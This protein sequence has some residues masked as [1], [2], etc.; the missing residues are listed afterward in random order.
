MTAVPRFLAT[1]VGSM[2]HI[3]P[4][5][6]LDVVLAAAPQA[7]IWPQLPK[8][9]FCEQMEVQ[10]TEGLP[11]ARVDHDARKLHFDTTGDTSEELAGFYE[12]YITAMDPDEG[13]GD[14][15]ALALSPEYAAGLYALKARLE[16]AGARLPF[17]KVQTTGPVS[18]ALTVT[19]QDKRA[20][21]YNEEFRDMVVKALAMKSRWQIQT[22]APMAQGV[23]CF[24][25]EP[26]LSA[27]GSSTYVSVTRDDVVA[28]LSE[29]VEAVHADGGLA[30]IHCCGNTEWSIPVD[31]G[32]DIVNFDAFGYGETIAIYPDAVRELFDRGGLL[33]WGISPS[34]AEVR[35]QDAAELTARLEALMDGLAAKGIAKDLILERCIVTSSCGTGSMEVAD[36]EKVFDL[37][38]GVSQALQDKYGL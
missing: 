19:D 30:G 25:D 15:S 12:Q 35:N 26:I 38:R 8:R 18:F 33:A 3:D 2:P 27:F 14:C 32:A 6:A 7:P 20:L 5:K 13:T 36:A 24:I 37:I 29:V 16:G 31:A 11:R 10:Y 23:I 17:I 34:S 9:S 21:Y 28:M 22:F 1:A 4:E